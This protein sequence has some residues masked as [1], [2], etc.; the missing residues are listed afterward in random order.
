MPSEEV[1]A[2]ALK[3]LKGEL[4]AQGFLDGDD[5][6]AFVTNVLYELAATAI[7]AE[8]AEVP[9]EGPHLNPHRVAA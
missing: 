3:L 6:N 7:M 4:G 5:V 9:E 2:K 1:G 8:A